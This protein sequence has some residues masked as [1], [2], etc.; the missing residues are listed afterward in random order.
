LRSFSLPESIQQAW[1]PKLQQWAALIASGRADDFKE[2]A[3]L[4]DF[5]RD[6]FC[7]LVGYTGPPPPSLILP[8]PAQAGRR[9]PSLSPTNGT[10][11]TARLLSDR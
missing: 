5:L 1:Q 9:A 11:R 7:G 6:I 8:S 10:S 4:P 2:T 3:L